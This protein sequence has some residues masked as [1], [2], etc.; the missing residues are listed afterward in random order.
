M[1][2]NVH[3]NRR[4]I[5]ERDVYRPT[6]RSNVVGIFDVCSDSFRT[7]S[8]YGFVLLLPFYFLN[9]GEGGDLNFF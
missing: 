7:L 6:A 3:R 8:V 4:V 5:R 9:G 1:V 2:F